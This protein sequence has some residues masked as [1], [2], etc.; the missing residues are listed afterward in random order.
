MS[1]S[2]WMSRVRNIFLAALIFSAPQLP[3]TTANDRAEI[4]A[5][6]KRGLA[7]DKEAVEQC[8]AKLE[9]ALAAE[10]DNQVA[11]VY[12]G[13]AFTL[14]SRDLWFG[15][16]KLETL[17]RGLALMDEAV[18]AAPRDA[19][20][21]LVRALTEDAVP[22]FFGRKK[23]AREDF[24]I[25]LSI[26]AKDPGALE[27]ADK[28]RLYYGAGE[29]EKTAGDSARAKELWKNAAHYPVDA[30]LAAKVNA[31]LAKP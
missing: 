14:R 15:P 18:A 13:S 16:R 4:R 31:A 28:Q 3:A 30:A 7:G 26:L 25:A 20:V 12:L 17:K 10:P 22:F 8:I 2:K 1:K 24:E 27:D 6:Y 21:R 11:R 29:M 9:Q 19:T 23:M 5:L